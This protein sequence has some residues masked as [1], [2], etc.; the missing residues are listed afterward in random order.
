MSGDVQEH[1]YRC[2][3]VFCF[4]SINFFSFNNSRFCAGTA[5]I[6]LQS[7]A[8][9]YA[10]QKKVEDIAF[11]KDV[12]AATVIQAQWRN[13]LEAKHYAT[14]QRSTVTIQCFARR[15]LAFVQF[16][17]L[18]EDW[19]LLKEDAATKMS[20]EWKRFRCQAA[21]KRTVKCIIA[22]QSIA[23]RFLAIKTLERIKYERV[24]KAATRIES[25]V[26][27]FVARKHFMNAQSLA[28]EHSRLHMMWQRQLMEEKH[29]SKIAAVWKG[30]R[31]RSGY[32]VVLLGK[33]VIELG[34]K[35]YLF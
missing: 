3:R 22:A 23:R 24:E 15:V 31:V 7:T 27:G 6:L 21:F 20:S 1:R 29:A 9:R 10:A 33:N 4:C 32:I 13:A 12:A 34:T 11:Q 30:F 2:V 25:K 18:K 14:T 17:Q 35:R 26:R 16:N 28:R 19:R 5:V 8:R